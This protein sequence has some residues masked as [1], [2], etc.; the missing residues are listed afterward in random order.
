MIT[1]CFPLALQSP[2]RGDAGFLHI[3]QELRLIGKTRNRL[4]DKRIPWA[5]WHAAAACWR[6]CACARHV[7]LVHCREVRTA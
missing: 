5:Q 7:G 1:V 3:L 2:P 6:T 4:Y